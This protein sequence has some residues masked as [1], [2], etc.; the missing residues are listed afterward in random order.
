MNTAGIGTYVVNETSVH[1]S[2]LGEVVSSVSMT[3]DQGFATTFDAHVL[4]G[5]RFLMRYYTPVSVTKRPSF[6]FLMDTS[7]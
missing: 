2:K 3:I 7:L 4:A 1:K 5:Y 6:Y